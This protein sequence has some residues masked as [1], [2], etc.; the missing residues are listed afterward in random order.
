MFS[1]VVIAAS[2]LVITTDPPRPPWTMCGTAALIVFHWPVRLMSIISVQVASSISSVG[3]MLEMPALASTMSSRPSSATPRSTTSVSVRRSR[4][5]AWL[6][7]MRR[8][9][10]STSLTVSARSSGLAIGYGTLWACRHRSTAM[11]SAPSR[12]R[13][14]AWLRP[15]P[16]AAPVIKATLP[17]SCPIWVSLG[18]NNLFV[19]QPSGGD[20]AVEQPARQALD[21]GLDHLI[22]A[23]GWLGIGQPGPDHAQHAAR[24]E[25]GGDPRIGLR[26][27]DVHHLQGLDG[28][29]GERPRHRPH[30]LGRGAG[31]EQPGVRGPLLADEADDLAQRAAAGL[32]PAD[33][34]LRPERD[35]GVGH[36]V[37]QLAQRVAGQVLR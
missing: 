25:L 21:E 19:I 26:R 31:T 22:G 5:S 27:T 30:E 12:A 18:M 4:M 1:L 9:R 13:V 2:E 34:V 29:L 35:V 20:S 7:M 6:A 10:A 11:M 37:E 28:P 17:S 33:D 3:A 23:G 8:S 36:H 32:G 24:E 14:M 15:W 16:R